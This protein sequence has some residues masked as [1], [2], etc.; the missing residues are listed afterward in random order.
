[1]HNRLKPHKIYHALFVAGVTSLVIMALVALG[2]GNVLALGLALGWAL[3]YRAFRSR[4][5]GGQFQLTAGPRGP[6]LLTLAGRFEFCTDE[7]LLRVHSQQD[8]LS[9][10]YDELHKLV[11]TDRQDKSLLH[12]FLFESAGLTDLLRQYRDV[13]TTYLAI[14]VTHDNK[15]IPIYSVAQYKVRELVQFAAL[16]LWILKRLRLHAEARPF[17]MIKARQLEQLF[18][19]QGV[20]QLRVELE[21]FELPRE[22]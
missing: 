19:E 11:L 3:A 4:I 2:P 21:I 9:I 7:R 14:L 16:L 20:D 17:F 15:A 22:G 6:T 1:M 8:E 5:R 18:R 13:T 12:E 10:P